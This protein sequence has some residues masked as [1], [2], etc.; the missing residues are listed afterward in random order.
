MFEERIRDQPL[1]MFLIVAIATKF[2]NG[3]LKLLRKLSSKNSSLLCS[4]FTQSHQKFRSR[5]ILRALI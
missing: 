1:A 3:F 4:S 5:D 2:Y